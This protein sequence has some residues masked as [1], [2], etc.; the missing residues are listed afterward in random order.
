MIKWLPVNVV[1]L[2]APPVLTLQV[3]CEYFTFLLHLKR[4]QQQRNERKAHAQ[5]RD[6]LSILFTLPCIRR[7]AHLH[8]S[9]SFESCEI[10]TMDV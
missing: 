3:A 8:I 1:P 7:N 4:Q 2:P 9:L 6:C 5:K 10:A